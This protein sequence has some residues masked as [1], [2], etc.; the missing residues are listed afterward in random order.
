VGE[1]NHETGVADAPMILDYVALPFFKGLLA[2]INM[3]QGLSPIDALSSGRSIT[4]LQLSAAFFQICIV[5][6]GLIT[7]FG[8]WM[9][10]RRELAAAES[11][12]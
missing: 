6:G 2:L 1:V 3:V 9:F 10:S 4:W 8:I 11:N 7:A 12:T 5:L